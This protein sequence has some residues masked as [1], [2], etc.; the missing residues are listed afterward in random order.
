MNSF[1]LSLRTIKLRQFNICYATETRLVLIVETGFIIFQVAP[2]GP[3]HHSGR[4]EACELNH[5][6]L[7]SSR[8]A[9]REVEE[10][11][12]LAGA[13][14]GDTTTRKNRHEIGAGVYSTRSKQSYQWAR[15]Y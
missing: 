13:V 1:A 5:Y 6:A 8:R 10:D 3:I 12:S 14:N 15:H 11:G 2:R 9:C 7:E 4:V